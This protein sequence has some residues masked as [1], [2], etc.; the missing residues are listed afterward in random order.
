KRIDLNL[1][2]FEAL[3]GYFGTGKV[4]LDFLQ[5]R[6]ERLESLFPGVNTMYKDLAPLFKERNSELDVWPLE[7][8]TPPL[9]L[10]GTF[11]KQVAYKLDQLIILNLNYH[12]N[13]SGKLQLDSDGDGVFDDQEITMNLDPLR[14]R[15]NGVCL[16]SL[17][18]KPA[19]HDRCHAMKGGQSCDQTLDSDGDSLNECEESLLGTDPFQFDTDGDS[20]PDSIEWIFGF[21]PNTSDLGKDSNSDGVLNKIN[22]SSG[23]MPD[24]IFSKI[25]EDL[26]T[27]YEVNY[28][29]KEKLEINKNQFMAM[30]LY[31]V[32]LKNMPTHP[33]L[34]QTLGIEDFILNSSRSSLDPNSALLNLIAESDQLIG[35]KSLVTENTILI[36]AKIVSKTDAKDF[37]WRIN[38][39]PISTIG[40]MIQPQI[41]LGSLKQIR[42]L[43]RR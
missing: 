42:T 32:L 29:G 35:T 41:D 17:Y 22:F 23:L 3:P 10:K 5:I 33:L 37:Y 13:S 16:D 30:D 2:L 18:A 19:Y 43:D 28:T 9:Q 15:T 36:L 39:M 24:L 4:K 21:N 8:G 25:P 7:N 6:K 40:K 38:K 14:A 31:E 20:L 26:K 12:F 11:N 34:N 1:G 27:K